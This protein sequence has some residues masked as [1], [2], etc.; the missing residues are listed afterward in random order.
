MISSSRAARVAA[1]II[2]YAM[3]IAWPLIPTLV[4]LADVAPKGVAIGGRGSATV[5]ALL[6]AAAL[7]VGIVGMLAVFGRRVLAHVPLVGPIGVLIASE[8]VAAALGVYWQAGLFEIGCQIANLIVFVA[9]WHTMRD[10]TL[11][12]RV[13]ACYLVTGILAAVFAVGLT[14]SRHPPA[15]FAYEHGRAAGTFLQPNEFAGYMLFL[16]PLGIGQLTAPP[17]LRRL[18]LLAAVVG[19]AGLALSFSRAA[20]LGACIGMPILIARFGRRAVMTYAVVAVAGSIIGVMT[21]RDVAHDP[22]ENASRIAV[23]RG[24]LRIAERYALTGVGPLNFSRIYP[25]LKMPDAAVDEVHAH[26]LPLNTLVENGV[27]GLA[28]LIWVIVSS[29]REARKAKARIP[30][31]DGERQLLFAALAAAFAASAVQN[32]VDLV[33]TF[34]FLLWWPMLGL[35]LSLGPAAESVRDTAAE[36]RPAAA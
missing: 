5:L 36:V 3:A 13:I 23:W 10:A 9:F 24:A 18:G 16:I 12:H 28:A 20:W 33:S 8:I 4:Q 2:P 15:A 6:M 1:Q 22:S 17:A 32:L 31:D 7:I 26:D 30:S 25:T 11:R 34:V 27:F 21:L 19:C 35:M 29:V 14:L